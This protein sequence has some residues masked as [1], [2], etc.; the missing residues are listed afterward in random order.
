M[1]NLIGQTIDQ[2]THPD[3]AHVFFSAHG[4]PVSYVEE[5][6]DP[7]QKEIEDCA[8]LI[9]GNLNRSISYSLAYQSRVGPVGVVATLC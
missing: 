7:Y 1:A 9:M 4:V 5:A 6:G 8:A 3:D 2:V